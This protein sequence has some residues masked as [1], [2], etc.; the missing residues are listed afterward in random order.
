LK[1]LASEVMTMTAQTDVDD[2][3]MDFRTTWLRAVALAWVDPKFK[4]ALLRRGQAQKVLED[5]FQFHWP[6][7]KNTL[8]FSV[9]EKPQFRWIG[10]DWCWPS[11]E[12]DELTLRLP[13]R[14]DAPVAKDKHAVAL[15]DYYRAKPSIFGR[16]G[17]AT[18][19]GSSLITSAAMAVNVQ[20]TS[21]MSQFITARDPLAF[22][23]QEAPPGGYIPGGFLDFEVVLISA[24][25]K[26]WENANF[27]DLL[28]APADE[29]P[30]AL[31]TIKGYQVPW[32]LHIKVENDR[33]ARW[34]D[35]IGKEPSE[36]SFLS[37][38]KLTLNL[39][40]APAPVTEQSI[41]LAAYNATGAEFPFSCCA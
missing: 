20:A 40:A 17:G 36:W 26:A 41:A 8:E 31:A 33:K 27:A 11:Q 39:P 18:P 24:L 1:F 7:A 37:P 21:S 5:Y 32:R 4:A 15:A 3:L 19:Q 25:A 34:T 35:R 6:W 16:G 28:L 38:H 30:E 2:D 13:V 29:F 10:S 9:K 12:E 14:P 23:G 22:G